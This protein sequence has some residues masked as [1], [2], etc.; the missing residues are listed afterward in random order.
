MFLPFLLWWTAL[1][2][3]AVSALSETA[4]WSNTAEARRRAWW[5][6]IDTRTP[7]CTYY[8]GPYN[9]SWEARS[10]RHGFIEDLQEEGAIGLEVSL[11]WGNPEQLTIERD[12]RPLALG[13]ELELTKSGEALAFPAG[14][15]STR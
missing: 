4:L 8:F 3:V 7:R 10:D 9:S 11:H 2:A 13:R 1:A 15:S 12:E 5:L 6:R 14:A